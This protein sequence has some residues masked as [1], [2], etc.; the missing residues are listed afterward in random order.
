MTG[1]IDCVDSWGVGDLAKYAVANTWSAHIAERERRKSNTTTTTTD[2]LYEGRKF[3]G[4]QQPLMDEI[5]MTPYADSKATKMTSIS[6]GMYKDLGWEIRDKFVDTIRPTTWTMEEATPQSSPS[7]SPVGQNSN[8]TASNS[9][10]TAGVRFR[11][12]NIPDWLANINRSDLRVISHRKH[13]SFA[14][15]EGWNFSIWPGS[16]MFS[17]SGW[18]LSNGDLLDI[19]SNDKTLTFIPIDFGSARSSGGSTVYDTVRL[20]DSAI[21]IYSAADTSLSITSPFYWTIP[22]GEF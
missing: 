19:N 11:L 9:A 17:G 18:T 15:D 6:A 20:D 5:L 4:V 12:S 2:T 1:E 8:Y 7:F 16:F 10:H 22:G 3:N 21:T 13:F 14:A